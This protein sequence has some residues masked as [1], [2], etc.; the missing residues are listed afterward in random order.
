MV[1]VI[2]KLRPDSAYAAVD[3]GDPGN[4]S[5]HS[6]YALW[7]E[8]VGPREKKLT[9]V[10]EVPC[11]QF[12][13]LLKNTIHI[14]NDKILVVELCLDQLIKGMYL[15]FS[16]FKHFLGKCAFSL[17][18]LPLHLDTRSSPGWPRTPQSSPQLGYRYDH[19]TRDCLLLTTK[20]NLF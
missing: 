10:F 11:R 6:G 19:H 16:R 18:S 14:I 5:A 13:P 12:G 20:I 7:K 4:G 1:R 15:A 8:H 9:I 17:L 3:Q 2:I